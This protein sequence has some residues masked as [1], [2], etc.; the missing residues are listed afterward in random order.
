[1]RYVGRV[2]ALLRQ[3]LAQ[4]ELLLAKRDALAQKRRRALAEQAALEPRLARLRESTGELQKLVREGRG[5]RES[6][7]PS[8]NPGSVPP[9]FPPPRG[10]LSPSP[11]VP[12]I[13]ADISKRYGGRPVNL[14]GIN[15]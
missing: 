15:L 4:A 8:P 14:M 12:Q 3:K 6:G 2:T 5:P 7:T 13:E 9:F 10:A 11:C 1:P